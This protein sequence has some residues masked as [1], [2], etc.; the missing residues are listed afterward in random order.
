MLLRGTNHT[1]IESLISK[2]YNHIH[3]GLRQ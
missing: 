1:I 3:V 2:F